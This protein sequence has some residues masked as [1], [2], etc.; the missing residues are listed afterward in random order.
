[1]VEAEKTLD[2]PTYCYSRFSKNRVS[3]FYRDLVA[4]RVDYLHEKVNA[5]TASDAL[6]EMIAQYFHIR[7]KKG[8]PIDNDVATVY[9]SV[10][11]PS[12]DILFQGH[13]SDEIELEIDSSCKCNKVPSWCDR[14]MY[15]SPE[16]FNSQLSDVEN[17]TG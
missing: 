9:Q 11:Q 6:S 15:L 10:Q 14:I 3:P 8:T 7:F 12:A 4:Q 5:R 1:L 2:L 17:W 13:I 16:N